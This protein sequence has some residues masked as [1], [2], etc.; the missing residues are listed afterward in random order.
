MA[1][2][3]PSM[4]MSINTD[5]PQARGEGIGMR[6]EALGSDGDDKSKDE[7]PRQLILF[8]VNLSGLSPV[9][10]YMV[11]AGGLILFM[12]LYGYYQE[13]V[14]YGWFQRKLSMFSTF[15]HFLGCFLFS[16]LQRKIS[17]RPSEAPNSRTNSA[18]LPID[19]AGH[20]NPYFGVVT[21]GTAPPRT[22]ILYYILLIMVRT[23][24][25]GFSN[26]SMTQINYPAKVLF[27]SATPVVTMIIGLAWF[28]KSYPARDYAVV[29]LL[30]LGLYIFITGD[31]DATN[32]PTG[33]HLGVFYVTLSLFGSAAI[34]MIQEH[35]MVV[36]NASIEDLLYHC[37]LGSALLSFACSVATGEMTQGLLFLIRAGSIHAWVLMIAL[38]MFGFAGTNFSAGL[39][40]QYG[41]LVNGITNTF[42]KGVTLGLSFLL[43]PER[44]ILTHQKLLGTAIFFGGLLVRIFH[45]SEPKVVAT[46]KDLYLDVEADGRGGRGE[47]GERG[48][49]EK[50][51]SLSAHTAY[52]ELGSTD[53]GNIMPVRPATFAED[54]V[55]E[56]GRSERDEVAT[57]VGTD[58]ACST[59][60]I[61][62]QAMRLGE[63]CDDM[64]DIGGEFS[65]S[66]VVA[67]K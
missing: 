36:Y 52:Y 38:S 56:V 53:F 4:V 40:L 43:F 28:K 8:G 15:L 19:S 16:L 14:I 18:L 35:C 48:E 57:D 10:Q 42:R 59:N 22:A 5:L 61:A 62:F 66:T 32:T 33:T 65:K 67:V 9:V 7:N 6:G 27:K 17:A 39:T 47:R 12:V 44:N 41:S 58:V 60:K 34:P 49:R 21:L 63:N 26:L 25:Q 54:E 2:F 3:R 37:F 50:S 64:M 20:T 46:K 51:P 45:K 13:L 1:Y 31:V 30:I 23:S 29:F 24:S 11:L 55:R